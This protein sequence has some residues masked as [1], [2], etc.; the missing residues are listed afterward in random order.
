MN[1]RFFLSCLFLIAS[2]PQLLSAEDTAPQ[3]GLSWV[4]EAGK[5]YVINAVQPPPAAGSDQ[6]KADL[7][8]VLQAQSARTPD[9]T[10]EA[11][12]DEKFTIDLFGPTISP[13]FTAAN[14]PVTFAFL[15]RVCRETD[16]LTST[17]QSQYK[18]PAPGEAHPEIK[19]LFRRKDR[20]IRERMRRSRG[21]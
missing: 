21:W 7:Q 13:D 16:F 17:L 18:R 6:E 19:S 3:P 8:A 9:D 15:N 5:A 20:A 1:L 14:Y 12:A 11:L 4:R 2:L 10:K